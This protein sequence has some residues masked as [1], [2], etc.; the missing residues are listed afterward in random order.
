MY[1]LENSWKIGV[2]L[3][4]HHIFADGADYNNLVPS[5]KAQYSFK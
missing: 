2:D 5:F 3:R 4:W 1:D